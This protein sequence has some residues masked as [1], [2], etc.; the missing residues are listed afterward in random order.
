MYDTE[1]PL[2]WMQKDLQLAAVSG[3]EQGVSLPTTNAAK[4]VTCWR[5]AMAWLRGFRRGLCLSKSKE[6]RL[7]KF[8]TVS[9]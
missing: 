7:E 8:D 9:V 6:N 4:E 1:F 5:L 3:Y 2:Q